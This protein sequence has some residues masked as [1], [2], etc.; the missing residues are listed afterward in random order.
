MKWLCIAMFAIALAACSGNS[1]K[2]TGSKS[3]NPSVDGRSVTGGPI[4]ADLPA[5]PDAGGRAPTKESEIIHVR[6]YQISVPYGSIIRSNEFWKLV[7][8]DAVDVATYDLLYRNGIR[9]GRGHASDAQSFASILDKESN[10]ST[11]TDFYN[12]SGGGNNIVPMNPEDP[13]REIDEESMFIFDSHGL[14]GRSYA[15]CQNRFLISFLWE[16]HTVNT[17]RVNICPTV[18]V[19]RYRADWWLSDYPKENPAL[20]TE[21]I[22]DLGLRADLGPDDLLIIGATPAAADAHRV[23]NLFLTRDEPTQR[24]EQILILSRKPLI[25]RRAAVKDA[26]PT[27]RKIELT[28]PVAR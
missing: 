12:I 21:H 8:E 13:S 14:S 11:F 28:P 6:M 17:V 20:N 23:G 19:V 16:P 4:A 5:P 9:V 18:E 3:V 7:D 25:F 27:T 26:S 10:R 2:P 15:H 1:S 24:T 22:Y